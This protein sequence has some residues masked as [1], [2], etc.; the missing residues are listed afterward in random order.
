MNLDKQ[1]KRLESELKNLNKGHIIQN[2]PDAKQRM[3]EVKRSAPWYGR[4][5]VMGQEEVL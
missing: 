4:E 3:Y 1:L 2:T 5:I